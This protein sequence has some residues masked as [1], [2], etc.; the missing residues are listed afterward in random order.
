MKT[1]TSIL[2]TIGCTLALPIGISR[3]IEN[4]RPI[5]FLI[6]CLFMLPGYINSINYLYKKYNW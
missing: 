3:I 5:L 2:C 4:E 1:V 6:L